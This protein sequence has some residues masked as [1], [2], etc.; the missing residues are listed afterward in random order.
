MIHELRGLVTTESDAKA[1]AIS[2]IG[3]DQL[4]SAGIPSYGFSPFL[5][6][7]TDTMGIARANER[8]PLPGFVQ[9]VEIYR[10]LVR[11]LAE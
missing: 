3:V 7:V 1:T 11:E 5:V 4:L 8:M 10:K 6:T 9:G 2:R